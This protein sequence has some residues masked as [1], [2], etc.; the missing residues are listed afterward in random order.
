[1]KTK[2]CKFVFECIKH[3]PI[4]DDGYCLNCGYHP[5][6]ESLIKQ[7][8]DGFIENIRL[9]GIIITQHDKTWELIQPI[10]DKLR[11]EIKELRSINEK[12]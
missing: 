1:M 11:E 2:C 8:S 4:Q 7:V 6:I 3:N 12:R 10:I 5:E 9:Q